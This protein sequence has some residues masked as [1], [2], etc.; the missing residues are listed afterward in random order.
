MLCPYC[1]V[2]ASRETATAPSP[3]NRVPD[4]RAPVSSQP[5]APAPAN[6]PGSATVASAILRNLHAI[7]SWIRQIAARSLGLLR[8]A[9]ARVGTLAL[10]LADFSRR[11]LAAAALAMKRFLGIQH[12]EPPILIGKLQSESLAPMQR[13]DRPV[14]ARIVRFI[15]WLPAAA[16]VILAA[17]VWWAIRPMLF[18]FR[19]MS[20]SLFA[21]GL[22]RGLM[23]GTVAGFAGAS[24]V[25]RIRGQQ[26][27][28][29]WEVIDSTGARAVVRVALPEDHGHDLLP[30][31]ELE[32]WGKR[33]GDGAVRASV[34]VNRRNAARLTPP[35]VSVS[36]WF[37][38][39]VGITLL[40]ALLVN[41]IGG[42][43]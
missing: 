31:D 3:V 13:S 22:L 6:D 20:G 18:M 26:Q 25:Q 27:V 36:R 24:I 37:F 40:A 15:A 23:I 41:L 19:L 5:P 7:T 10:K 9:G 42:S 8:A 30:G 4:A 16:V 32:V 35:F 17:F 1:S 38:F 34:V 43:L 2:S 33:A 12:G 14:W 21:G 11:N 28:H 29:L 39:A